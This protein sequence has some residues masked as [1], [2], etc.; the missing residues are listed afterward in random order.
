MAVMPVEIEKSLKN[1]PLKQLYK[2]R[3]IAPRHLRNI[4]NKE[5]WRRKRI[6]NR[7]IRLDYDVIAL[8]PSGVAQVVTNTGSIMMIPIEELV[9]GYDFSQV[10]LARY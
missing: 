8:Y 6:K 9:E 4:I 1:I 10:A 5:I 7:P 2:M 3:K